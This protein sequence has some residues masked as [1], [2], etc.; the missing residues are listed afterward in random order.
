VISHASC[1]DGVLVL[2]DF[3][4]LLKKSTEG[5]GFRFVPLDSPMFVVSVTSVTQDNSPWDIFQIFFS[6]ELSKL[7][8]KETNQFEKQ[9]INKKKKE[10][11]RICICTVEYSLAARNK[12]ILCNNHTHERV[13]QVISAELLE[14]ASDY[15]HT[16][17]S[18]CWNVLG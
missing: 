16:I 13:T 6:P 11:S 8:K 9:Q 10:G 5:T 2:P 1:P 15:S 14:F 7:I 3:H 18:F 12:K 4:K 17:C